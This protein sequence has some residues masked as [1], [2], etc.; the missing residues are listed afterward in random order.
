ME[1]A[2]IF[3]VGDT[4]LDLNV[5]LR[6]LAFMRVEL[7][8]SDLLPLCSF[9][10]RQMENNAIDLKKVEAETAEKIAAVNS[11]KVTIVATFIAQMKVR[12]AT[13]EAT[14]MSLTRRRP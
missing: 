4:G 11:Q 3:S 9:S 7:D 8:F 2:S 13:L 12:V 10:L 5:F 6:H 14:W 1:V